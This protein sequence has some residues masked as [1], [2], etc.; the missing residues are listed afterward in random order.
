MA[1]FTT[2]NTNGS[3]NPWTLKINQSGFLNIST[4]Q[5]YLDRNIK[6]EI[7]KA[8]FSVSENTLKCTTS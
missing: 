5:K 8:T 2:S 7:P 1:L 6:L 4:K 3:P